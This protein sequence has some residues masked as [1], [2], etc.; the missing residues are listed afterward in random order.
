[1]YKMKKI[2]AIQLQSRITRDRQKE[3]WTRISFHWLR[4]PYDK[5]LCDHV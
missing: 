2:I 4:L 1:M 5:D 3:R